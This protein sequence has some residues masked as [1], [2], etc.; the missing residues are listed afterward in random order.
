M[1]CK[2][3]MRQAINSA[4]TALEKKQLLIGFSDEERTNRIRQQKSNIRI[5]PDVMI[6]YQHD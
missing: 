2:E 4:T 5:Y 1:H 3:E 6:K